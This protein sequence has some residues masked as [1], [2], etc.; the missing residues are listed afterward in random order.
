ML[1]IKPVVEIF[2]GQVKD[3]GRARTRSRAIDRLVELTRAMRPVERLAILHTYAPEVDDLRHR[4]QDLCSPDHILT[5]AAT[6]VIGAHV[7]PLGLGVA[8]VTAG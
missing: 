6:T 2:L 7:G 5:V 8:A 3:M 4:L 1:R